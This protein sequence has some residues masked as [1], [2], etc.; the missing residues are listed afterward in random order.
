MTSARP[1]T[2]S[3]QG[4]NQASGN[5]VGHLVGNLVGNLAAVR[6]PASGV[7]AAA[8]A[9]GTLS[10]SGF[11]QGTGGRLPDPRRGAEV[12][13]WLEESGLDGSKPGADRLD[14]VWTAHETYL[15]AVERL[16]DGQIETWL[17][18]Y[19]EE[20]FGPPEIAADALDRAARQAAEHRR[21]FDRLAALEEAFWAEAAAAANLDETALELLRTRAV[22]KRALDLQARRRFFGG[23]DPI[24]LAGLI[25]RLD[26]T[27][28]EEASIRERLADHDRRLAEALAVAVESEFES[29]IRRAEQRI[30]FERADADRRAAIETEV[31]AA[32]EEG[33]R[34]D[35]DAIVAEMVVDGLDVERPNARGA[36]A[37]LAQQLASLERLR[38]AIADERLAI[39]LAKLNHGGGDPLGRLFRGPIDDKI[40]SGDI[41]PETAEAIAAIREA[42]YRERT[43]LA[44]ELARLEGTSRRV[45]LTIVGGDGTD[46]SL[47]PDADRLEELRSRL[48]N[49]LPQ[50]VRDRL[51]G[52]L[53]LEELETNR[54]AANLPGRGGRG[55]VFIGGAAEAA[56]TID[57]EVIQGAPIEFATTTVVASVDD[58][59]EEG[60][61]FQISGPI[62]MSLAVGEGG[63]LVFGTPEPT[64]PPFR[65]ISVELFERVLADVALGEDLLIV[66]EQLRL[67]ASDRFETTL[68][69][70]RDVLKSESDVAKARGPGAPIPFASGR[71]ANLERIDAALRECLDADRVMFESLESLLDAEAVERLAMWRNARAA[72]LLAV[73]SGLRDGRFD[74][75]LGGATPPWEPAYLRLEALGLLFDAVPDATARP[76]LR[77][78]LEEHVRRHRD[79]LDRHWNSLRSLVPELREAR[80]ELFSGPSLVAEG[81]DPEALMATMQARQRRLHEAERRMRENRS[82]SSRF[83]RDELDRLAGA[84]PADRRATYLAT[85][86]RA[87]WPDVVPSMP[88]VSAIETAR[89][90]VGDDEP[91]RLE[92]AAIEGRYLA[93]SDLLFTMLED[94]EALPRRPL[95]T[96][97]L[98]GF[99]PELMGRWQS[100]SGRLRFR[101]G[102]LDFETVRTLRDLVGPDG[103]GRIPLPTAGRR[104]TQGGAAVFEAPLF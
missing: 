43:M 51:S 60:R 87:A 54:R 18:R 2:R 65:P 35:L 85:V 102:E 10:T 91:R 74:P 52:L 47:E 76:E 61:T 8:I 30:A 80:S 84:V 88:A 36:D 7:L 42:Y 15:A 103:A 21:L 34:P 32:T 49:E 26:A 83:M 95:E 77:P 62:V 98:G 55:A 9:A 4:P 50:Q 82:S 25:E 53:Q 13:A 33:R 22:R 16:R 71:G 72:E 86:R 63:E 38:G 11:A 19:P 67:D 58:T 70:L 66:A 97:D 6:R 69:E 89:E 37:L 68:A 5:L 41:D 40:A 78:L 100:L 101:H 3:C 96:H 79:E 29:S 24:D 90:L 104:T 57:I 44:F 75:D 20:Q 99:S 31:A 28:E 56:G 27:P 23:V 14:A 59:F 81:G 1:R 17:E 64:V 94:L 46:Q 12:A 39:L 48:G 92:L 73:A 93:E 45:R